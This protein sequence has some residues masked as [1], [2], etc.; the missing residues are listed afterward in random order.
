ME[1]ILGKA[2]VGAEEALKVWRF[3]RQPSS[4]KITEFHASSLVKEMG[5]Q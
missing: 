3:G 2:T 1:R 5:S 4:Q